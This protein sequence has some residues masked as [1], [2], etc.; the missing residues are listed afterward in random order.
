MHHD[1]KCISK[2]CRGCGPKSE[3]GKIQAQLTKERQ[4]NAILLEEI[5]KVREQLSE[6]ENRISEL[7]KTGSKDV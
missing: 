4:R 7:E 5:S 6:A 2:F 1:D 3:V